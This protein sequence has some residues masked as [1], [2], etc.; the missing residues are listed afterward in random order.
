L[1]LA[2]LP[3]SEGGQDPVDAAVRAAATAK[4]AI[5]GDKLIEFKPFDPTIKMSEARVQSPSVGEQRVVKGAFAAIKPLT[6]PTPSSSSAVGAL[7]KQGYRVLAVAAG[8][9]TPMKLVGLIGAQRSASV[10][11]GDTHRR[12]LGPWSAHRHGDRGR[13]RNRGHRS[14]RGRT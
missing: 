14:A 4:G 13:C 12:T 3:S 2:A 5:G 7:E 11:F 10:G 6:Q 1:T 8:G 9:T